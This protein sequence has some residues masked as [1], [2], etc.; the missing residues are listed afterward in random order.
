[1]ASA[2]GLP[3][4]TAVTLI[5]DR[6]DADGNEQDSSEWE[7]VTGVI[8][9]NN[10]TNAL[11][12]EGGTS[13][14]AH[15]SGAVVEAVVDE[16]SWNDAMTGILVEHSQDGTHDDVTIGTSLDMDGNELILDGDGDTSIT[17]DTDDQIDIKIANADDFQ[18]TANTFTVLSGSKIASNGAIDITIADEGNDIPLTVTQN[19]TTNNPAA[20]TITNAGTGNGLFID[21]NGEGI[22]L[23]IDSEAVV[24][25]TL[26]VIQGSNGEDDVV[27]VGGDDD[28]AA[29]KH[30][31]FRWIGCGGDANRMA[32]V[33]GDGGALANNYKIWV[34]DNGDLRISADDPD[35]DT[36]GTVVG[37]QS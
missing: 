19:D 1:L 10:L 27:K 4:D 26:Q 25:P 18:F 17:A 21:Q 8:S 22:A 14:S 11:R 7:L 35:T 9:G 6:V 37:T 36:D 34:D 28:V 20:A 30:A 2:S 29:G 15:S 23:S 12:G 32:L 33:L 5:I 13:A 31:G 24:G 3:T 16:E